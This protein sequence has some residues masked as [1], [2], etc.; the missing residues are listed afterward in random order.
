MVE[1]D[2][3]VKYRL[4]IFD[5]DGTLADSYPWFARV[6]DVIRDAL[7]VFGEALAASHRAAGW[8]ELARERRPTDRSETVVVLQRGPV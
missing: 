5:F 1:S 7:H 2:Q 3:D 4:A 6:I 8:R